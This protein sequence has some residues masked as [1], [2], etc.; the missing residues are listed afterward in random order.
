MSLL[1]NLKSMEQAR[2]LLGYCKFHRLHLYQLR[3]YS[4]NSLLMTRRDFDRLYCDLAHNCFMKRAGL[5]ETVS[6]V[7]DPEIRRV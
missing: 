1:S 4:Q 3:R 6:G 5:H 7:A 2:S